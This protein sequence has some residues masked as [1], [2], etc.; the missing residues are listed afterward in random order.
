MRQKE[1]QGP[2]G[3]NHLDGGQGHLRWRGEESC[4]NGKS[5]EGGWDLTLGKRFDG[6]CLGKLSTSQ[7]LTS[8]G[9]HSGQRV[10]IRLPHKQKHASLLADFFGQSIGN[11]YRTA[12]V[13]HPTCECVCL[14]VHVYTMRSTP[15]FSTS[16][17]HQSRWR[18]DRGKLMTSQRAQFD[19]SSADQSGRLMQLISLYISKHSRTAVCNS[20]PWRDS[21][22]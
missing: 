19:R 22:V 18:K 11:T 9:C 3:V 1:T 14:R 5:L 2:W 8:C 10:N 6:N 13:L 21:G 15:A 17:K 4:W 7:P 16:L 20:L 12:D